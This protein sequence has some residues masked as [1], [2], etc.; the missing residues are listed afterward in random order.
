LKIHLK[1]C[2][3]VAYACHY[4]VKFLIS[5]EV[6]ANIFAEN[7]RKKVRVNGFSGGYIFYESTF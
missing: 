1:N 4:Y 7:G 5:R 6:K 2:P 3:Q